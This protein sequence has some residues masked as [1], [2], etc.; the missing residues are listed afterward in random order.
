[1]LAA[2]VAAGLMTAP[3]PARAFE[4]R[5]AFG[6]F[7]LTIPD[8][9][10]LPDAAIAAGVVAVMSFLAG[11]LYYQGVWNRRWDEYFGGATPPTAPGPFLQF[12]SVNF[13]IACFTL[14]VLVGMA[15]GDI[16]GAYGAGAILAG[17][18]A[19]IALSRVF[20]LTEEGGPIEI[21]SNW[22]GLGGGLGGWRLSAAAALVLVT[23]AFAGGAFALLGSKSG[24]DESN[25]EETNTQE[26]KT[27]E[28]KTQKNK[29][30]ENKTQEN[31]THDSGMP[32]GGT[33]DKSTTVP[34]QTTDTQAGT[35]TRSAAPK[36]D[37]K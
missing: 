25:T 31:K 9:V 35:E 14:V 33:N 32:Q 17:A 8:A 4:L 7:T 26:T 34:K 2:T 12:R 30:Q 28:N 21:E 37:K 36:S 11:L 16:K 23:L 18:G 27:Q 15:L 5:S 1:M 24:D 20:R 22:G 3:S 29:P 13:A 10:P 6:T 19:L